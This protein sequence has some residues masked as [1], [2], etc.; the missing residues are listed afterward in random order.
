MDTTIL[1]KPKF[2]S[3]L[4]QYRKPKPVPRWQKQQAAAHEK[5]LLRDYWRKRIG[6]SEGVNPTRVALISAVENKV[7]KPQYVIRKSKGERHG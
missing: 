1:K 4:S 6:K 2:D 7:K 5:K 3:G